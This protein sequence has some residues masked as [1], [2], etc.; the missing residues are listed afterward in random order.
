MAAAGFPAFD[1]LYRQMVAAY[2]VDG[3]ESR[4]AGVLRG[5]VAGSSALSPDDLA[6]L[7]AALDDTGGGSA[8]AL[9][10]EWDEAYLRLS[11]EH[12]DDATARPALY[13]GLERS[14]LASAVA[15]FRALDC[16]EFRDFSVV[17]RELGVGLDW[18]H[19]RL[20]AAVRAE[21]ALPG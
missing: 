12:G 15:E 20:I 16:R 3:I 11:D 13:R 14:S 4:T 21:L 9:H 2:G 17:M 19:D 10:E 7:L 8:R 5:L 1:P 6:R 18:D